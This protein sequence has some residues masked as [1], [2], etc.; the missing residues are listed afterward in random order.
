MSQL[1][2]L[3]NFG[4]AF[5]QRLILRN[6]TFSL[7][8]EGCTVLLGPSGTGKSTLLRT[9]AGL[10]A[11]NSRIRLWGQVSYRGQPWSVSGDKP[12]LVEQ[13]PQLLVA[14]VWDNL[15]MELPGRSTLSRAE[16]AEKVNALLS[17]LGQQHLMDQAGVPVIDLPVEQQRIVAII[18][19]AVARP[20]LLLVDEPTTNLSESAAASINH[21]LKSL[22]RQTPL[23]VVSHHQIHTREIADRVILIANGVVQEEASVDDFFNR[24]SNELTRH[25]LRTGSCPE[26]GP[27][28][29]E[30]VPAEVVATAQEF[31]PPPP[32][33]TQVVQEPVAALPM[34][35]ENYAPG[36]L[37]PRGFVWLLGGMVGGTPQPGIGLVRDVKNDLQALH[38][39]GINHLVSLTETPFESP[40]MKDFG[41][42]S[43][44][45][46]IPDMHAPSLSQAFQLC[47]DIDHLC[48]KGKAVAIH[49]KA[50]LGRTGTILAAYWIWRHKGQVKGKD[51]IAHIRRLEP[52]MI[53]SPAQ[54]DFLSRFAV[55]LRTMS[56]SFQEKQESV[57]AT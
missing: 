35:L 8:P 30:D 25:F 24:P 57:A 55:E 52:R 46:P 27:G 18:R 2:S 48:A 38:A 39:V 41:I 12:Q 9:L 11:R 21:V 43:S 42:E 15:V 40:W 3:E 7:P 20:A 34:A 54:E 56:L 32:E 17:E 22:A 45:H 23:L 44:F 47:R 14:S 36:N 28:P 6:I 53:Q 1:L 4:I 19:K 13:K 49:C 5:G 37:G 51:A 29:L 31:D 26:V 16:Q 10:M 33:E 50:G